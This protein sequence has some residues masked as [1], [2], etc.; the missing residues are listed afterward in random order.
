MPAAFLRESFAQELH[1]R[2]LDAGGEVQQHAE[3][4]EIGEVCGIEIV[5]QRE[6]PL[7]QQAGPVIIGAHLHAA[8]VLPDGLGRRFV[9]RSG[10][11]A[12][13]LGRIPTAVG[14]FAS[15][16]WAAQSV[17]GYRFRPLVNRYGCR[18]GAVW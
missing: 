15:V 8:L 16:E 14:R 12:V 11:G 10:S 3:G 13:I 9:R 17:H 5:D 4:S 7:A 1:G 2:V 6:H 18:S